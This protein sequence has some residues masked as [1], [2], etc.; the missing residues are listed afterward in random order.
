M[1]SN[2]AIQPSSVQA[3]IQVVEHE[4]PPLRLALGEDAVNGINK[5]LESMK[6]ELDAWKQVSI[7]T[8]FEGASVG[9]SG[10]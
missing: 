8:A 9:A 6:A 2:L 4:N 10:G 1:A 7:N 5:K 3:M